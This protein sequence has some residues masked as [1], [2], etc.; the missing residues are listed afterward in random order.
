METKL[1]T[2]KQAA[3]YCNI[4]ETQFLKHTNEKASLAYRLVLGQ[5]LYA[6]SELDR[7]NKE[8]LGQKVKK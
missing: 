5:R 7:F 8:V 1:F 6:Q 4:S 2:Y 3:V